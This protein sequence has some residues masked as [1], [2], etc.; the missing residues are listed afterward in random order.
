M[1]MWR[2]TEAM[3]ASAPRAFRSKIRVIIIQR[4][5][6]TAPEN[7]TDDPKDRLSDL[8]LPDGEDEE[9]AVYAIKRA[10]SGWSL[11]RRGLAAAA[12]TMAAGSASA[13]RAQDCHTTLAH[14]SA[15]TALVITPDGG[16]AISAGE[17]YRVRYW[18]L[19][20][21]AL[22]RSSYD[23]S[24]MRTLLVSPDGSTLITPFGPRI[25]SVADATEIKNI[26]HTMDAIAVTPDWRMLIGGLSYGGMTI[27]SLPEGKQLRRITEGVDSIRALAVSPTAELLVGA[28]GGNIGLWSLPEGRYLGKLGEHAGAINAVAISADGR[29][30]VSAADDGFIKVWT[31]PGGRLERTLSGHTDAVLCLA[32]GAGGDLL[33][34]GGRDDTIRFW[35]LS[36]GANTA[37]LDT[38]WDV[39]AVALSA[40]GSTVV[41]GTQRGYIQLWSVPRGEMRACFKDSSV[42]FCVG[43]CSCVGDYHYWYPN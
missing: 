1:A 43:D 8:R 24:S 31:L 36:S 15:V 41:S 35:S 16:T 10:G 30:V 13:L 29:I 17:D 38:K 42:C 11:S 4:L 9:P 2:Q 6:Y 5:W 25:W 23:G 21:G 33:V 14:S 12:A 22:L 3:L 19:P 26:G 32:L 34:S 27:W 7:E 28:G 37:T 40:D 18:R 20:D 39:G